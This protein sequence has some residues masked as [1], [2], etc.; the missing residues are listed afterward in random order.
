MAEPTDTSYLFSEFRFDSSANVLYR[1][2]ERVDLT[3]KAAELLAVLLASKGSVVT[4]EELMKQVWPDSFVEEA[5]L[6]HHIF[7]LR[8]ALGEEKKFIETVPKRGYRFVGTLEVDSSSEPPINQQHNRSKWVAVGAAG[9]ITAVL[10]LGAFVYFRQVPVPAPNTVAAENRKSLAITPFVNESG[11]ANI[12]Y[13]SDGL[14]EALIGRLS[15][16]STIRVRPRAAVYRYK[17]TDKSAEIIGSEL[18]VESVLT[19]RLTKQGDSVRLFLSLVDVSSGYQ[20]WGKQYDRRLDSLASLQSDVLS[21][22]AQYLPA[23]LSRDDEKRVLSSTTNNSEAYVLYL[24]GRYQLN[25]KT[26][27][28]LRKAIE[29]FDSAAA[30]DPKFALA[31]AGIADAYNEMGL[32][33]TLPP[34]ETYPKAR[35]AAE[36]ALS[37]DEDLAE[38]HTALAIEQFYYEW[39]FAGAEKSFK[40]AIEL[41]PDYPLARQSYAILLYESD[42]GRFEQAL[43]ELNATRELDPLSQSAG[44]WRGAFYYFS[45]DLENAAAELKE[46]QNVDPN[47]TLGIGLLGAVYREKGMSD[48][49]VD[50][51]LRASSL[52]G[53]DLSEHE[54]ASLSKT[55]AS[56][57]LKSYE[58]AYAELLQQRLA[59]KYVSPVFIAMHYAVADEREK[60]LLWLDKAFAERS[61]WLVELRVD[62]VWKNLRSDPRFEALVQRVGFPK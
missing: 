42:P 43:E 62:P 45:G 5:N 32:W 55:Y 33:V 29:I 51:W 50:H 39:D 23:K 9:A 6:S 8:Q 22:V 17:G 11:D 16:I 7:K 10:L 1:G 61:S 40:R 26:D 44:F 3:P 49:Y 12:D 27:D 28:G 15:Q 37:L 34:A 20:S 21:D 60:A 52:E 25:R 30:L 59:R 46:L 47:Y 54:I 41:N 4:K 57:G 18:N 31:H 14:T 13:L 53:G 38:A 56:H 58:I 36:K 2:S 24:K 35:A 48:E 19:G